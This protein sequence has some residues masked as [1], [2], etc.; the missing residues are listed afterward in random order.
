MEKIKSLLLKMLPDSIKKE[1]LRPLYRQYKYYKYLKVYK[2]N[3]ELSKKLKN[4]EKIR[5]A[6][7]AI[8]SSVWKYDTLYRL[9]K[10]HPRFDPIIIVCPAV[11]FGYENMINVMN[12]CY[13]RFCKGYNCIK[14][15]DNKNNSYIDIRKDIEPDII[16]YTNPY[17]GLIDDRYYINQYKDILTCYVPYYW[18]ESALY[19]FSFNLE[20]QNLVWKLYSETKSHKKYSQQYAYNKGIN[21]IV[22]GYPGIDNLI[23]PQYQ[24]KDVW[25]IKDRSIKRIIWAPHHTISSSEII[26]YSCFLNFYQDMID[27]AKKYRNKIQIAFKPHPLLKVKLYNYW[28]KEKTDSYYKEWETMPNS[29]LSEGDYIDLFLSSDGI[30]HD[31]GSFIAEYLYTRKPALHTM[32]NPKTYEEFNEIGKQCLDVY[33]HAKNKNE[34]EAFIINLINGKD[35]LFEARNKFITTNLMPPNHKLASENIFNDILVSIS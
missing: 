18:G 31:S 1:I 3:Q 7:L 11:N 15:Y 33:Y 19:D 24:Y 9:M 12:E 29:M 21:T 27:F 28:G 17:K 13:K 4:K 8:H 6:F 20:M 16:F 35:E 25:K 22:S 26:H 30:I 32:T 34:I 5:V 2:Q 14:A 10:K 23:N